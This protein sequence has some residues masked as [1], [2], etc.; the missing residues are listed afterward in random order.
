MRT[1]WII[2]NANLPFDLVALQN[3]IPFVDSVIR[4]HITCYSLLSNKVLPCFCNASCT[5]LS[6]KVYESPQRE[7]FLINLGIDFQ[8]MLKAAVITRFLELTAK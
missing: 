4:K 1:S 5:K 7:L 6:Q 3:A 8:A 2:L